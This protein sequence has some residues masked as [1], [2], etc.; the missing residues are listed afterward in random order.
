MRPPTPRDPRHNAACPGCGEPVELPF[1]FGFTG[2]ECQCSRCRTH[3]L[4]VGTKSTLAYY[5]LPGKKK[6][7]AWIGEPLPGDGRPRA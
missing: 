6:M 7:P 2:A 5:V 4:C 3:F 1:L